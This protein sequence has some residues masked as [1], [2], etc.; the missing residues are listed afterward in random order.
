[1]LAQ[2]HTE[3][4][5]VD[6]VELD[7]G[8][9]RSLPGAERLCAAT[10]EVRPVEDMIRFVVSP[11]GFAV[12]DLK[13]RLPG[14]GLWI[15][16]SREALSVAVARKLFGRGF[17]RDVKVATDLPA[18]TERLLEQAA[19]DALAMAH[20][21]GRV[22]IGFGKTE[23][24]LDRDKVAALLRAAD[25]A[26]DGA[27]KLD[28]ALRRRADLG[29]RDIAVVDVFTSV[30][31]D[32]AL[33]RSNVIHAALLAGRESDTFMARAGRLDRFRTGGSGDRKGPKRAE[34]TAVTTEKQERN[35]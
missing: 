29:G 34:K 25:A 21:A 13:R 14:R 12:A 10:G 16:A 32:L 15:T 9:R 28:A 26:A 6:E 2:A 5:T 11:D 4:A 35:G 33:G 3:E 18:A 7:V 30:Q 22:A 24:A 31:L 17:K 8:L 27:R 19:L 20:K 1:M 23:A